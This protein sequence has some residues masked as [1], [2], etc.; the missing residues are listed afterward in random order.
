MK[1]SDTDNCIVPQIYG[2]TPPQAPSFTLPLPKLTRNR[3]LPRVQRS[4]SLRVQVPQCTLCTLWIRCI[5]PVTAGTVQTLPT[6]DG[7]TRK[8][9]L[10]DLLSLETVVPHQGLSWSTTWQSLYPVLCRTTLT[11]HSVLSD[12]P[13][14]AS[15]W[16]TVWSIPCLCSQCFIVLLSILP[17]TSAVCMTFPVQA[18]LGLR[19]SI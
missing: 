16:S 12:S 13:L 11:L 17:I 3:C 6:Q 15:P 5:M 10:R 9:S 14:T 2:C 1:Q 7:V 4:T 19:C 18:I 8:W